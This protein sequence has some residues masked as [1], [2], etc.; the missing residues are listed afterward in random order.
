M[1]T[2]YFWRSYKH[3]GIAAMLVLCGM[4]CSL[5]WAQPS[6]IDQAKRAKIDTTIRIAQEQMK[7]GFYQQAQTQL[8]TLLTSSE[9]TN[10][11]SERQHQTITALLNEIST[12]LQ[13]R[14]KITQML[15]QSDTLASQGKYTEALGLLG[16]IKDSPFA[17]EQERQM[18]RDLYQDVSAKQL[19]EQQKWQSLYDASTAAYKAGQYEQARQGFVQILEAGASVKG[20][21]TAQEYIQ[22]ID[23]A[24]AQ[25]AGTG[26]A[27]S[28]EPMVPL[29]ETPAAGTSSAQEAIEPLDLMPQPD[30]SAQT[31]ATV[32]VQVQEQKERSYLEVVR[33][34]RAVQVDYTTAIV[35]DAIEKA[36]Q[37]L[38]SN[39]FEQ[40]QQAL[41]RASSTVEANKMLLGDA[42]YADYKAQLTNLEQKTEEARQAYQQQQETQRQQQADE[43]NAQI[44]QTMEEQRARAVKDYLARAYAFLKEQRHEDALGQLEQLLAIDP[45]N[46]EAQILK[47]TLEHMDHYIKQRQIQEESDREEIALLLDVKR[48]A[49]PYA[50]EF[51][52]PHNWKE[53]SARREQAVKEAQTPEDMAVNE[54]LDKTVDLSMLTEDTTLAEAIELLRNSVD[55]PLPIVVYWSDLSQNAFV[56]K[57]TPINMSGEGLR[58]VVLRTALSR[59]LQAVGSG[60]FAELAYVVQEG[61]VTVATRDS[62]PANYVTE[63]YDVADLLNPPANY[64]EDYSS[65]GYGGG[66]YG[67]GGY[68]GGGYGG[69][70]GV[71]NWRSMYRAYML[72]YT[73]QQT[74]EPSTWYDEGGEGRIDQ[75]S[76]SKLIIYQSPE[77]HKQIKKLLE[78]LRADLGQQIAIEARF[79]L[80]SE[81]FLED[82]GLDVNIRQMDVGGHW[83][84]VVIEQDSYGHVVPSSTG[85]AGSLGGALTNPALNTTLT[86]EA[87]DDLQ[88]EF[89]LRATQAHRNAKQ[90]SAPKAV[91]LNNESATMRVNTAKRLKTGS[92]FN[93]ETITNNNT[94]NQ[95]YWWENT[96]EDIETGVQ[97]SI[98]PVITADKKFVILRVT[99]YLQDLIA[100]DTERAIGFS[101]VTGEQITDTYI[102]PTTQL[103]SIQTRVTVPDR[104]TV[105]L[106]GL[107]LTATRETES[108]AP[109]LSKLPVLGRLFSNRSLVDDKLMLLILVKPTIILQAEAEADAVAALNK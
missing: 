24:A 95:V 97:L 19:Q 53:I 101:P 92:E 102:L 74:V 35:K 21:K 31:V 28:A 26:Q 52:F 34:K 107:T 47:Q 23:S 76:E 45:L 5:L 10:Y 72:I 17:S 51:N 50:D 108:G 42:F 59:V 89:I 99:A 54:L 87:L 109:V 13:E 16:Q 66:G 15:Q 48:R 56:E 33:Q 82:I 41:R 96:N 2:L 58:R 6:N 93:T 86:Y 1:K 105:L 84:N 83:G 62:L 73:I 7:R 60:G 29:L 98:T 32:S 69:S 36:Q 80:V 14:T 103:T 78:Q 106:G 9:Y 40:A 94:T 18:I 12:A 39:Q 20:D 3:A 30:A 79:L 44:R 71:G 27:D 37:A 64:D 77:V 81:N 65:S 91:V 57:T 49:I 63:I 104:G 61:T 55:P 22:L 67:G 100:Q 75:Y 8:N 88:V 38:A 70:Q 43:L 11:L 68:G 46:Q 25:P 85:V 4:W 90:L